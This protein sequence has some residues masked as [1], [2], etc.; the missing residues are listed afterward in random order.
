MI[1]NKDTDLRLG[2]LLKEVNIP[3]E[4][5]YDIYEDIKE[6]WKITGLPTTSNDIN[7]DLEGYDVFN[8]SSEKEQNRTRLVIL[9][10]YYGATLHSLDLV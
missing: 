10:M 1:Q 5:H 8:N 4:K 9:C 3:V 6:N 2:K 7:F